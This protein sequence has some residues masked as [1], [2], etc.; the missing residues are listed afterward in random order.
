MQRVL[1]KER[2][3]LAGPLPP[4]LRK[5]PDPLALSRAPFTFTSTRAEPSPLSTA[6]YSEQCPCYQL[7]TWR[8][9]ARG[10][11]LHEGTQRL[12]EVHHDP[13]IK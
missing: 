7:S 4:P 1:G 2:A 11:I 8:E 6:L 5:A 10:S 13:F 9:R 3:G 12:R